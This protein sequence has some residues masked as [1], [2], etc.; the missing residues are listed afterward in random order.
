MMFKTSGAKKQASVR[1]AL[2]TGTALVGFTFALPAQAQQT[3]EGGTST[4]W[5][6]PA[7]W[8][9][10][11]PA[12]TDDVFIATTDAPNMPVI[13]GADA[14][15][16]RVYLG[17]GGAPTGTLTIQNGGTLSN[18]FAAIG[19][20]AGFDY[21]VLVTGAGSDWTNSEDLYVG[22]SGT[23]ALEISD[24]GAVSNEF[25]F[26]GFSAGSTGTVSVTGAGSQWTNGN[27]LLVGGEGTGS[28]TISDGGT[29]SN[30]I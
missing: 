21:S 24:G 30:T 18:G 15:A 26:I 13:D 25:G 3:W 16:E 22:G 7:N 4:D 28:L 8:T 1:M 5:F 19:A 17:D 6:D 29:V 20:D 27:T 23:G 10:A 9:T 11:V 2:L 12:A 14:V